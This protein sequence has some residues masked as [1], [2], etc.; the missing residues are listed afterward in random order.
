MRL[1]G[2]VFHISASILVY[3]FSLDMKKNI[4]HFIAAF[5]FHFITDFDYNFIVDFNLNKWIEMSIV[6][7]VIFFSIYSYF[8]WKKNIIEA[9]SKLK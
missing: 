3:S 9:N 1:S 8:V 5:V 2:L 4:T 6:G 7:I